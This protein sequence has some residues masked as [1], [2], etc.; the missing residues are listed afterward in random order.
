MIL[1]A[2]FPTGADVP[3]DAPPAPSPDLPPLRL[4]AVRVRLDGKLVLDGL[5][6]D[7][8]ERRIGIV[9]R[10]GS[11]KTTLLRAMAGLVAVE[12]GEIRIGAVDPFADRKATLREIGILF[13]NPDRQILFP[14]V[15][16]ELGFGLRQQGL[17]PEAADT[18]VAACLD[19]EGRSHW[20]GARTDALS[21]GQRQHL[22]LLAVLLMSPR[23]LLLD[24]PFAAIDLPTSLR[25]KR[26]LDALPQRVV[27]VTQDPGAVAGAERVIWLEA[28]RIAGDGPPGAVLP[29]FA[30]D[31]ARRAET[32]A[33]RDLG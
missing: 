33:D 24:E 4:D 17:T 10:N 13:Q 12:D 19:A 30:A 5:S 32:D 2:G 1:C 6:L 29:A 18:A 26:R 23:T 8:H 25:L 16:E 11:G 15:A 9:G 22:C 3:P 27:T 21:Q 20:S 31:M 7:L 28:G 14:T